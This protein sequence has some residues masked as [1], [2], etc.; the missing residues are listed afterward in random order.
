LVGD[1][2][3]AAAQSHKNKKALSG[4]AANAAANKAAAEAAATAAATAQAEADVI[5][6]NIPS[7]PEKDIAV[8][9]VRHRLCEPLF[10]G[11]GRSGGDSV[12]EAMGRA[13]DGPT[14]SPADKMSVWEGVGVVG[15]LAKIKCES[16][17]CVSNT[18]VPS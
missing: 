12:W 9:P 6:I 11:N 14:M 18:P 2:A 8:G 5:I 7:F 10:K 13:V 1:N 3:P 15:E 16:S 4:A 17:L